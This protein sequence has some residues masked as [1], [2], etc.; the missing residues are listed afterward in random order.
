MTLR[1]LDHPIL[2]EGRAAEIRNLDVADGGQLWGYAHRMR[3]LWLFSCLGVFSSFACAQTLLQQRIADLSREA[4]GTV[5]VACSLPG[6]T[7]NC[8]MNPRGREPMLST[9]KLPLGVFVLHEVEEGKLSLNQQVRFLSSDIYKGTYSPLQDEYPHANVDVPL[10][11][12]L[13]LSVGSSDNTA[14]D[15]LLRIVGGPKRVQQYLDTLGLQGLNVRDTERDL[16]D[17]VRLQYR[18]YGEPAAFVKLLRMLADKSPLNAD[19]TKYLLGIMAA[20]PSAPKRLRGLLPEGTEVA[21][22]TGSSG[23]EDG[24]A[25]ATNDVGL[26]RLPDGRKLALAVLVTDARADEDSVEHTIASIAKACYDAA[27]KTDP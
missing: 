22:K 2:G 21:H 6:T 24:K 23:Y 16:H 10:S 26:I 14:T 4:Q 13:E 9:F 12:L 11:K 25:T 27:V 5:S 17:D 3:S 18:N 1:V 7:L 19:H 8:D 15:I 20:S